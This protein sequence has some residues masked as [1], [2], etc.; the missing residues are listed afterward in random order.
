MRS[1]CT[2]GGKGDGFKFT[3]AQDAVQPVSAAPQ[4]FATGSKVLVERSN[5]DKTVSFV[6][7]YEYNVEED[8]FLY[9][10]ELEAVGSNE[11]KMVPEEML[12]A[13]TARSSAFLMGMLSGNRDGAEL[14]A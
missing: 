12:H 5:G 1:H 2:T 6:C 8:V 7:D 10:V 9:K 13:C 11:F 14:N 4:T 3:V